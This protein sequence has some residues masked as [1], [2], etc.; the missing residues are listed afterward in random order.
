MPSPRRVTLVVDSSQARI[1]RRE[2]R[3]TPAAPVPVC[4]VYAVSGR[5]PAPLGQASTG[6]RPQALTARGD[7]ERV[8]GSRG[9]QFATAPVVA[10]RQGTAF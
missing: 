4:A 7:G 2:R 9:L 8:V 6:R 5:G 3:E 1:I 10:E